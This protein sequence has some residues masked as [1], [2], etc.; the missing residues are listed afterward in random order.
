M[1]QAHH[2]YTGIPG[3]VPSKHGHGIGIVKQPRVGA[4]RLY[5]PCEILHHVDGTQTAEDTAD[6]EGITDGLTETVLLRD[7]KVD[8][9]ARIV[10]TYLNCIYNEVGASESFLSVF[11]TEIFSNGGSALVDVIVHIVDK[12]EEEESDNR[13]RKP[14]IIC[15]M[16]ESLS[17][18]SVLGEFTTNQDYMPFMHSESKRIHEVALTLFESLN[19]PTVLGYELKH[20]VIIDRFGHYP[21]RNQ[22]LRRPS[23]AEELEFLTQPNSSF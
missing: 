19:D 20:K 18:L 16:N 3:N 12:Q 22:V 14:N 4:Y 8:D 2:L 21:H 6:T 1:A 7:L 15:I 23:S 5:I 13:Y 9:G 17:D 11:N 10:K